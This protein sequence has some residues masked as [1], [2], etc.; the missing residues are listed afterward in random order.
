MKEL[1][2][3]HTIHIVTT[4]ANKVP[5]KIIQ[6]S[7]N[8][9]INHFDVTPRSW[10]T[11]LLVS[12]KTG[13]LFSPFFNRSLFYLSRYKISRGIINS[14]KQF[15]PDLVLIYPSYLTKVCLQ[16]KE[17]KVVVIGPDCCAINSFRRLKDSFVYNS[18]TYENELKIFAKNIYMENVVAKATDRVCLVGI[19]DAIIFNTITQSNKAVFFP[20]PHYKLKEKDTYFSDEKIKILITGAYDGTTYTDVNKMIEC[21]NEHPDTFNGCELTFIGKGWDMVKTRIN[22]KISISIIYWVDDYAEEIKKYDIQIFPISMG[23][24]TKGKV[25]DAFAMGIL[26]IGSYYA[27]ENI[28]IEPGKSCLVYQDAKEI[29]NHISAIK[30][31]REKYK[32]MAE[33]GKKLIR[34]YH[35]PTLCANILINECMQEGTGFDKYIY[36]SEKKL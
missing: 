4:N 10:W 20:H 35:S 16:L 34:K 3:E 1:Q 25:L 26:C 7:K 13:K 32:K 11:K 8:T 36:F 9:F 15:A 6:K 30:V 22:N 2:R 28:A 17:Y 24:G 21:I 12:H 18:R 29:V 23:A 5:N 19:K 31:D 33:L 27:F 14:I